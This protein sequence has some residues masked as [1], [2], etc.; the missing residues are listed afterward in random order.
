LGVSVTAQV[1]IGTNPTKIG[2]SSIIELE[3]PTKA[4][5]VTRVKNVSDITTP[6]NGMIVYDTFN[7]CFRGYER[8][9]WSGCFSGES[10]SGKIP[11]NSY[12][13]TIFISKTCCAKVCGAILN[14]DPQTTVGIE[15]DWADATSTVL[16]VGFGAPTKTRALVDIGGQ[17]WAKFTTN[18]TITPSLGIN[19]SDNVGV[20][21]TFYDAMQGKPGI[22]RTQGVC[23]IG[24]HIPSNSEW[25]FLENTALMSV[26][27]Q[28]KTSP[29]YYITTM[30]YANSANNR[31]MVGASFTADGNNYV[32]DL[33][34]NP[35]PNG[36]GNNSTGFT[37]LK[38]N[39]ST[40]DASAAY[41]SSTRSTNYHPLTRAISPAKA[42][43]LGYSQL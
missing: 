12:S 4:L 30:T 28:L 13:D 11:G 25:M 16:G 31:G 15:Y 27:D 42:G 26:T 34:G 6:I 8:K 10:I 2:T 14:D 5:L 17:C 19:T 35:T 1:K 32:V 43:L 20:T 41:F 18:I 3:D 29:D 22:E 9:T 37:I 36:V 23:P 21:Y 24:W 7:Q 40:G 39:S 38:I 33:N